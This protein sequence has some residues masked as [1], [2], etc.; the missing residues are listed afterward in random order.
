MVFNCNHK[1]LS[2]C[3]CYFKACEQKEQQDTKSNLLLTST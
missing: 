2:I 3:F 1:Y